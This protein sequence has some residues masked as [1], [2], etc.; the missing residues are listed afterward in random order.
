MQNFSVCD[1]Y[2]HF[3]ISFQVA[4]YSDSHSINSGPFPTCRFI[5]KERNGHQMLTIL[6]YLGT[7]VLSISLALVSPVCTSEQLK[8]TQ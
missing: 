7:Q 3:I 5:Q 2:I 8:D 6:S 4:L 1:L